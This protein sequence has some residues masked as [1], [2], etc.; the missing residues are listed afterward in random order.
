MN[1]IGVDNKRLIVAGGPKLKVLKY[2]PVLGLFQS[3]DLQF[4]QGCDV[5]DAFIR[6]Y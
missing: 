4:G 5:D 3:R 6:G 1:S 2:S